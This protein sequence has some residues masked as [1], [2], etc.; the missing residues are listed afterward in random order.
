MTDISYPGRLSDAP[1]L[2]GIQSAHNTV[3]RVSDN[4]QSG[5]P[6]RGGT[7]AAARSAQN[8]DIRSLVETAWAASARTTVRGNPLSWVAAAF[9][10]GAV[11]ARFTR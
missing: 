6:H 1:W 9:A 8:G 4:P 11:I 5:V 10:L 7:C 3:D 2:P